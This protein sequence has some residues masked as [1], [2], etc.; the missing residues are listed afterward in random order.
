MSRPLFTPGKDPVAIVQEAGWAPG[1][2]CGTHCTGGWVDPRAGLRYPLY[3][4]LGG[5]QV[6]SAV[7]IAQEA[8]WAP[9]P[10]CGTYCT[11]G[12]V[13]PKAGLRYPLYRRLGGPQGRFAVPLVQEAGWAPGPVCGTHC[14]G[15]WMG[16]RAGLDRCGKS[17][18]PPGFDPRTVQPLASRRN[19]KSL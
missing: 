3:R 4:R 8:G 9:G 1:P 14:T 2:F 6:R 11:G 10:V 19:K 15:G 17:R 12:W 18:L 5:P 13:G 7:P 16:P